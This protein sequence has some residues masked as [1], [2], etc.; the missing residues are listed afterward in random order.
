MKSHSFFLAFAVLFMAFAWADIPN[1]FDLDLDAPREEAPTVVPTRPPDDP[2]PV[3]EYVTPSLPGTEN[4]T[5]RV[6]VALLEWTL[7]TAVDHFE[8]IDENGVEY[9]TQLIIPV[10]TWEGFLGEDE[11][12]G[13]TRAAKKASFDWYLGYLAT[14]CCVDFSL[15][16]TTLVRVAVEQCEDLKYTNAFQ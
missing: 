7:G 10:W 4:D 13:V 5:N 6:A 3:D 2:E 1:V 14:N 8:S 11:T 12:N 15:M 9:T 16:Q